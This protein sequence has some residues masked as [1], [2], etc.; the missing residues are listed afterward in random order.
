MEMIIQLLVSGISLGGIYALLSFSFSMVISTTRILNIA[1]GV[2]FIWGAA[3]CAIMVM[4]LKLHP[5]IVL[6]FFIVV[7][8]AIAYFF[9]I[10]VVKVLMKKGSHYILSGSILATFGLALAMES[11]MNTLWVAFIDP[12]PT[13]MLRMEL[14][15][16]E[17]AGMMIPSN[18]LAVILLGAVMIIIFHF[19]LTK[20]FLGKSAR[21]MAQNLDGFLV[22]GLNPQRIT[23]FVIVVT[24]IIIAASGALYSLVIPLEVYEGLPLTL[25]ALTIIILA[26]VGS[27]PGTIAAGVLLG[28]AEVIGSFYL[29]SVWAPV[30]SFAILFLVLIVKPSGFF[31]RVSI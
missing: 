2:F 12:T 16:I 26:G 6:P 21:A 10:A 5:G 24:T 3:I 11:L 17:F 29:G 31:G 15:P 28:M 9:Y 4:H 23:L 27:L 25:K 18:R 7:F 8:A 20:T 13:F 22:L 1:H 14:P 30:I 19:L